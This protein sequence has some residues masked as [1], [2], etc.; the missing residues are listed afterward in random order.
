MR[1]NFLKKFS[2]RSFD[3]ILMGAILGLTARLSI[4]ALQVAGAVVAQ[5]AVIPP[6]ITACF[7]VVRWSCGE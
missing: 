3:W 7:A 2:A 1:F 4:S 6:L 5:G